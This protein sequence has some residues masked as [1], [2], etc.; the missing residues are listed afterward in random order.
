MKSIPPLLF[1]TPKRNFI[2]PLVIASFISGSIVD[3]T[4]INLSPG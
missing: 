3:D 2:N 1:T 4:I